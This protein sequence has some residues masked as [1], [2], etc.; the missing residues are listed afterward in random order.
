MKNPTKF[1]ADQEMPFLG[2]IRELRR[3][4]IISIVALG[5]AF[6]IGLFA[7]DDFVS[8][9]IKPFEDTLYITR[10]E[11]GFT[12]KIKIS[13]YLGL[14]LSFPVHLYNSVLF[15][16]PALTKKER[17]ILICFLIGSFFLLI[18]GGYT[19]YFQILPIS[20]KFLKS[21][22]FIPANVMVWLDYKESLSFVVQIVLAFLAL[23]QL[24]LVLLVLMILNVIDRRWLLKSSRYFIVIILLVSAFITPP[25]VVSQVGL[26]LPLILLF[27]ATILIGKVFNLG[28]PVD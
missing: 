18:F 12:T 5:V 25:D 27:Y 13:L 24:P 19:A 7:F 8:I 20:L 17:N 28:K 26:A 1:T 11:Q 15:I 21:G 9:L 23:F 14:I 2:H 3:R 22:S 6:L 16:L 4:L 10:I